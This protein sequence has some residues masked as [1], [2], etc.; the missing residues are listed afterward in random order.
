MSMTPRAL[1][2]FC[3]L[4]VACAPR[5]LPPIQW[6]CPPGNA[7]ALLPCHVTTLPQPLADRQLPRYPDVIRSAGESGTVR[8]R[9]VVDTTGRL[10]PSSLVV[11][12]A[13]R[14]LFASTVRRAAPGW[15]FTPGERNGRRVPVIREEQFD[16]EL[17]PG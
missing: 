12:S 6:S 3:A 14:E 8:V 15:R 13:T 9:Y 1:L 4:A 2:A 11:V 10:R 5:A 7:D 17:A 16:F